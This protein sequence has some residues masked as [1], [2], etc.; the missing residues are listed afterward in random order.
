MDSVTL[1]E[2]LLT[3]IVVLAQVRFFLITRQRTFL[4]ASLFPHYQPIATVQASVPARSTDGET[5]ALPTSIQPTG[6]ISREFKSILDGTN[7]YLEKNAGTPADFRILQDIAERVSDSA[8]LSASSN[9]TLP[10]YIGLMGTFVGVIV[11]LVSIA[12][13]SSSSLS[14]SDLKRFV[15]GVLVAMIGS[16]CGLVLSMVGR[17]KYLHPA[18]TQNDLYKQAYFALLQTELLPV[19]GHDVSSALHSLERNLRR[20]NKDFRSNLEIFGKTMGS[21]SGTL[22]QQKDLI[23]AIRS[24]NLNG[25]I[26]ANADMMT[27]SQIISEA[28]RGFVE[29][30]KS[31]QTSLVTSGELTDRFN[32]L[33]NRFGVFENNVN[34]LGDKL[35]VDHTVTMRTVQ[36]IKE[37]LDALK[38]RHLVITEYV[39]IQDAEVKDYI[40]LQRK[41]LMDL[42]QR[43][44]QQ[45]TDLADELARSVAEALS[46]EH[47]N[48]VFEDLAC[49]KGIDD[50]VKQIEVGIRQMN[51]PERE[52]EVLRLLKEIA[53]NS[54]PADLAQGREEEMVGLLK[55]IASNSKAKV[56]TQGKE[57]EM[58]GLLTEIA[59]NSK[60]KILTQGKEEEIVGLLRGIAASLKS[61]PLGSSGHPGLIRRL[62]ERLTR[63]GGS[64]N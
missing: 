32:S 61:T 28:L 56:L 10:L 55:E 30:M 57:E 36:L 45:L 60:P 38:S 16:L 31:L 40:A 11:G 6:E 9:A 62:Y 19:V 43:A 22:R 52:A 21:V 12:L 8:V 50:R 48:E 49:L 15:G 33:L 27:R 2:V 51:Q 53:S 47:T 17:V 3:I 1:V 41:K 13:E 63:F 54:R 35:A 39:D 37:Q 64:H 34:L 5:T 24:V 46:G 26:A 59:S 20:F 29:A 42:S 44:S 25:I 7:R 4:L 23:E 18:Q 14:D 58:V